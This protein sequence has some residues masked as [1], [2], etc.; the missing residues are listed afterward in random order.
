ML[1]C[2]ETGACQRHRLVMHLHFPASDLRVGICAEVWS[3]AALGVAYVLIGNHSYRFV[4][5]RI[6]KAR[7]RIG[8]RCS[9][10]IAFKCS[11][12]HPASWSTGKC[13][14][15]LLIMYLAVQISAS[16]FSV[17]DYCS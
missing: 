17:N 4:S 9:C 3:T 14:S 8:D 15:I 2:A 16:L 7:A 1:I 11:C 6:L 12:S 5:D 10:Y 13:N